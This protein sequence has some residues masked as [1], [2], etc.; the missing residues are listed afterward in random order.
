MIIELSKDQSFYGILNKAELDKETTELVKQE[1][2]PIE[3]KMSLLKNLDAS[4]MVK[5]RRYIKFS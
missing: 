3:I 5:Y 4:N 2:S 1:A